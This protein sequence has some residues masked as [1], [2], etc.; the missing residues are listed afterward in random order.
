MVSR[1]ISLNQ[2][3]SKLRSQIEERDRINPSRIQV[4]EQKWEEAN[5]V[6]E[7]LKIQIN[8]A[9][10]LARS[11]LITNEHRS[12]E[13]HHQLDEIL[14]PKDGTSDIQTEEGK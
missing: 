7:Q 5:R 13:L 1:I 9:K 12:I 11:A 2:D 4:L 3:N 6:A 10:D 14:I 8:T